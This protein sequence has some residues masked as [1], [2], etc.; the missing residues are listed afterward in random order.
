MQMARF[1]QLR[2]ETERIV[3]TRIREREQVTK[4]QLILFVEIQLAYMNTN[5][6]DFIGFAKYVL[7]HQ[8]YAAWYSSCCV[9]DCMAAHGSYWSNRVWWCCCCSHGNSYMYAY[10]D[11]LF[12]LNLSLWLN[13]IK[14]YHFLQNNSSSL[15]LH[16]SSSFL[17]GFH[18]TDKHCWLSSIFVNMSW[19]YL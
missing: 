13:G 16:I 9:A 7:W 5:H 8:L 2:E 19:L 12:S 6:E 17:V 11:Y 4:Q 15:H 14:N 18:S 1:P 10:R 3:N